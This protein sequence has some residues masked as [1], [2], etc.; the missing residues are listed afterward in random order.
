VA[1]IVLGVSHHGAPLDVRE[2][3]AFRGTEVLPTLSRLRE[4]AAVR[5]GVLLSTCNRT[6]LY[7]VDGPADAVAEGWRLLS[8]RLGA[9]AS[10][11]GYVRRDRDAAAHLFRVASGMD[12]LVVGEAQIHGQVRDAWESSRA[13]SGTVL[14]RLFQSALLV[15]GRVRSETTLGH[16]ALSVS[17]AAVQLAKKIFGGLAGRRAMVLGAGEM[18]ELALASLQQ[19]GVH[20]A[21]VANRTFERATELAAQYGASAVRYDEAWDALAE[22]DLLLCSTAA[23]RPVVSV[24]RVRAAV[25]VRGDRPLC[26]LD[27]AMP[28]DVDPAVR[29][30]DNVFL[31]DMDDL[32][33]VVS[34]NLARRHGALPAAEAVIGAEVEKYWQWV[35]GLAAVPV[36]TQFRDE[37]NRVRERELAAALRRLP[38]L[39]PEQRAAVEHFSQSLMNKF[40]HE[41]S[42]RLRAAAA[43]GRGLGVVDAARYL[44]ALDD[45]EEAPGAAEQRPAPGDDA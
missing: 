36:L 34:S 45:R 39:T 44:F 22:V 43:N 18:A 7:L 14:N 32:H 16:G 28:R 11:Y 3:L 6:E 9:D 27:I 23:P 19:E 5:E 35:A 40:L 17:T 15:G 21:I 37:M 30:L 41:P 4:Q 2:R 29:T 31:Y 26:I 8:E 10:A 20:A 33:A 38:D 24:E 12:S 13:A 42:V 25:E 1:V